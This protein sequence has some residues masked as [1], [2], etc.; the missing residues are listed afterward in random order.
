VSLGNSTGLISGIPTA[1][2]NFTMGISAG[3]S[4]GNSTAPG[5]ISIVISLP[6]VPIV[7][8]ETRTAAIGTPFQ[9]TINATNSPPVIAVRELPYDL[10]LAF[11]ARDMSLEVDLSALFVDADK[12]DALKYYI[13][14]TQLAQI[15]WLKTN[16][17][18]GGFT[19]T[20]QKLTL[21]GSVPRTARGTN[22]SLQLVCTDGYNE[23]T[24]PT[25][26][27]IAQGAAPIQIKDLPTYNIAPQEVLSEQLAIGDYFISPDG[28]QMIV[29]YSIRPVVTW[30]TITNNPSAGG[31]PPTLAIA[32]SVD[33]VEDA[34][35]T[36]L[37]TVANALG[38]STNAT[39]AI[40]VRP[41]DWQKMRAVQPYL[42]PRLDRAEVEDFLRSDVLASGAVDGKPTYVVGEV[43]YTADAGDIERAARRAALLRKADLPAVGLVACETVQPQTLA[44]AREQ[45]VKVWADG[46][47]VDVMPTPTS[48]LR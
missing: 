36:I 47:L 7:T 11:A 35:V 43:S 33:A 5:T 31:A 25:V 41:T 39:A 3:N 22:F 24:L 37:V 6:P 28:D 16:V 34:D 46:R 1:A 40:H 18:P 12:D 15:P 45:G 30:V 14:S 21:S 29:T 32:A 23:T 8:P 13:N 17:A 27:R 48:P 20:P 19:K 44:Y 10:G 38:D 42:E 4:A 2:G 9:F 26:L